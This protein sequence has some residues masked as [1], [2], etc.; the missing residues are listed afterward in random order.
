MLDNSDINVHSKFNTKIDLHLYCQGE[1][2]AG[3]AEE[4][5]ARNNLVTDEVIHSWVWH[6]ARPLFM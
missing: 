2:E 1:A 3:S 5:P 6:F 4:Q